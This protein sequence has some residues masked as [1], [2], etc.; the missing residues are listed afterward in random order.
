[1]LAQEVVSKYPGRARFV[2]ENFG[3]SALAERFGVTRYP[4]IFVDDVLVARPR[5]F[6][7]FAEGEKSGRYTPWLNAESQARFKKDLARM[8]ELALA[9]R[10]GELAR[11]RGAPTEAEAP[12]VAELPRLSISDIAGRPLATDFAKGR[13]TIVEF[14][15]TWCPPCRATLEHLVALQKKY[16]DR[17]AVVALAVESP[18]AATRDAARK[19][20]AGIRVAMADA[21]TASAFGDV[22]AV[23]TLFLFDREGKTARVFYG[24]PPGL[25]EQVESAVAS[26]LR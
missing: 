14:W 5:D 25:D 26:L 10:K 6:G 18:E 22:A 7:F 16:G 23:P 3:A 4:A 9:G 20:G 15:A 11:E 19:L 21:R 8:V 2:S 1:L 12:P 13:V 24:A 17:L